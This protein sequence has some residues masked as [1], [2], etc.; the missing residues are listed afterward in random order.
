MQKKTLKADKHKGWFAWFLLGKGM[1]A[2]EL[3]RQ[4]GIPKQHISN[5]TRGV[6]DPADKSLRRVAEVL[7]CS[8]GDIATFEMEFQ[9]NEKVV[10]RDAAEMRVKDA[11]ASLN[12]IAALVAENKELRA[13]I[14]ALKETLRVGLAAPGAKHHSVSNPLKRA[15]K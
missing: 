2:A 1:T 7:G 8:P 3:A 15:A 4:S 9:R 14:A 13:E 6:G 11:R 12:D 10:E 5:W